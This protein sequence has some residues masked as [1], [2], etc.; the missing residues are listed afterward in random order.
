MRVFPLLIL[1]TFASCHYY[2]GKLP[3]SLPVE[4]TTEIV[5]AKLPV[6]T[7]EDTPKVKETG[8]QK[9]NTGNTTPAQLLTYAKSLIGTPY[10]YGSTDPVNGFDCSG[11]IT[12]VFNHFN[13]AVPRSSVDFTHCKTEVPLDKALPGDLILFTGT[14]STVREVGHMGI[15]TTANN[16]QVAFIHSSSGKA[17]GVVITPLNTYYLGR[18]VKV[19][20]VF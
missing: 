19:I 17:M 14:D 4:E 18:F 15:I 10:K 3:A 5:P 6:M 1:L 2:N 20:R 16:G 13:I 8:G 11:F 7:R 9:I 12:H